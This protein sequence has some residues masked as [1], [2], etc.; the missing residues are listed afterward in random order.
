MVLCRQAEKRVPVM[1]IAAVL[2]AVPAGAWAADPPPVQPFET[3]TAFTPTDPIDEHILARLC[4]K[5]IEPAYLCSDTVF[6]RRVYLDV[7]GTLPEAR[8][9]RDFLAD[10]RPDKRARLIDAL[11]ER[12]EFADYWALKWCDLLRVKSEFPINLWPNAVQAYHHWVRDALAR[13]K[14]Y[15]AFVRE[16]LTSSGS[17]FRVPPVNFYRAVQDHDPATLAAAVALTFM[18]TRYDAWPEDRRQDMAAFFSRV[19]FK[20]TAEWK[21]E[22]VYVDPSATT[23]LHARFPDGRE[24]DIAAG[25]DPR[26]A[27]ADWLTSPENPWFARN[28]VNRIWAWLLGRGIIDEPDDIRP[29]NPPVN[30]E[31]L[32]YLEAELVASKYDLRHI[33]RLILNSHTYQQSCLPRSDDPDAEALFAYYPV[34]RLDAEVLV[35]ALNAICGSGERYTSAIPEP[36]THIPQEQ[37]TIALADGSISSPFLEMFGR[38]ARDTGLE[39]ERDRRSTDA[40][41]LHLL[42]SSHVQKKIEGSQRLRALLRP[43]RGGLR[44]AVRALYLTILSRYPTPAELEAVDAYL[45]ADGVDRRQAVNDVVWALINS[46]EFVFRH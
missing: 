43:G 15:D 3:D 20:G 4:Q 31:L 36:F 26:R 44:E 10:K 33:Y 6:V 5:K 32:T 13:N 1:L 30:P 29:D 42:N 45:N 41:R 9:V 21:E 39:S 16:L 27:F 34:R 25:D 46:K 11:L 22:I 38:P 35:D 28:V 37:R 8:E 7:I 14:P 24:I 2:L 18:G 17:N 40:Q 12:D 23:P 19:A